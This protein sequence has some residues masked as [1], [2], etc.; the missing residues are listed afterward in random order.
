MSEEMLV[1]GHDLY[2]MTGRMSGYWKISFR[3]I[4]NSYSHEA[5]EIL[6]LKRCYS[7]MGYFIKMDV[8][9]TSSHT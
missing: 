5:S 9:F 8:N 3:S 2:S 1:M 6:Q 4:K 7:S